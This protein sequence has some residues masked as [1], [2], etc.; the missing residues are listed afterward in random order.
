[1]VFLDAGTTDLMKSLAL[2]S[3]SAHLVRVGASV[4]VITNHATMDRAQPKGRC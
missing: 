3:V 2:T 4:V 1:M